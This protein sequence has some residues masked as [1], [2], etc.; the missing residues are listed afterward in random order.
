MTGDVATI[1]EADAEAMLASVRAAAKTQ[2]ER[3][4]DDATRAATE[5][6]ARE[7][8]RWVA[9]RAA[10][11]SRAEALSALVADGEAR[12]A[13]LE[14]QLRDAEHAGALAAAE[15]RKTRAEL[16]EARDEQEG[17]F[18][19]LRAEVKVWEDACV[20]YRK[21][22]EHAERALSRLKQRAGAAGFVEAT[23]PEEN[24]GG[25]GRH[26]EHA[27]GAPRETLAGAPEAFRTKTAASL[28]DLRDLPSPLALAP[29]PPLAP[30]AARK[31]A[32]DAA[33]TD[34]ANREEGPARRDRTARARRLTSPPREKYVFKN[35][36][37][38]NASAAKRAPPPRRVGVVRGQH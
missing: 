25:A 33:A 8:E 11:E 18:Q 36:F 38:T 28:A 4:L 16:D 26:Q 22:M 10:L 34:A 24:R 35:V 29:P 3:A 1:V 12:N 21:R 13:S 19:R 20:K 7:R 37:K 17:R 6:W 31:R 32:R 23:Q 5:S 27:D 15:T 9:E 14:E 2:M 30:V